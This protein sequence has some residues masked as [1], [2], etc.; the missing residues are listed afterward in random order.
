MCID[1][2]WYIQVWRDIITTKVI[3]NTRPYCGC[4]KPLHR[5]SHGNIADD[6]W[7]S[8]NEVIFVRHRWYGHEYQYGLVGGGSMNNSYIFGRT[9]ATFTTSNVTK[10][11]CRHKR[12]F[13]EYANGITLECSQTACVRQLTH[14]ATNRKSVD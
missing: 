11:F 2:H 3:T 6:E 13:C 4:L 10:V 14:I 12:M 5:S 8:P 1:T 7:C 9:E